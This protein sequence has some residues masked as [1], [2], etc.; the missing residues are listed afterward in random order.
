MKPSRYGN[1]E[2]PAWSNLVGW[3]LSLFSVSAIPIVMAM[4][5]SNEKGPYLER[6]KRLIRP[7]A[8]W[9]PML[10]THRIEACYSPKH[11]DSQVPLAG[12][13]DDGDADG[14]EYN[15]EESS[16]S[17]S[18]D[19][20]GK[21]KGNGFSYSKGRFCLRND[22]F[23]NDEPNDSE[24][25]LRLNLPTPDPSPTHLLKPTSGKTNETHF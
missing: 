25:G 24:A 17:S 5:V 4:Q 14:D 15:F 22:S 21:R 18:S 7:A 19:E 12:N 1:Y 10:Q 3:S 13:F 23:L 20:G 2:F 6:I 11:I 8:D 16:L 9:G